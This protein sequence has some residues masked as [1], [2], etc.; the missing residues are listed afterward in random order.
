M[1]RKNFPQQFFDQPVL[2]VARNLLGALIETGGER[3]RTS[4]I[5]VEVEAYHESEPASHSYRGRTARTEVM[6]GPGGF[7]YV[8]FIYGMHYCVNV[9]AEPVGIGAAVLIRAIEPVEGLAAMRRRRGGAAGHSVCNGPA[10]LCEALGIDGSF[11][12]DD[13]RRSKR[14]A[15]RPYRDFGEADVSV[16]RRIGISKAKTLPWRFSV[17]ENPWVSRG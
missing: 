15:V 11:S 7:C 6:F 1:N 5:I 12:G 9:V 10:K 13:L 16:S 4:G 8:Y 2:T 17:R 14:I 3:S